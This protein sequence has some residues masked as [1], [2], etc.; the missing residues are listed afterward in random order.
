MPRYAGGDD[1]QPDPTPDPAPDPTPDPQPDPAPDPKPDP[2][3]DVLKN[4]PED[5]KKELTDLRA[6]KNKTEPE[7]KRARDDAAKYRTEAQKRARQ[8]ARDALKEAGIDIPKDLED[9]DPDATSVAAAQHKAEVEKRDAEI[10]A[11]DIKDEVRDASDKHSANF[12][13]LYG[14]L[15]GEGTLAQLDPSADDFK[16]KVDKMVQD[17]IKSEPALKKGQAPSK[18][19]SDL[20]GG[21]TPGSGTEPNLES[22][23]AAKMKG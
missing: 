14:Y 22:A 21:G 9:D 4:L 23:I 3:D 13:V 5:V 17:A 1:P 10:K 18:S 19:G 7:L 6:F 8:A 20:N 16:A 12:K 11:R 15:T 2:A